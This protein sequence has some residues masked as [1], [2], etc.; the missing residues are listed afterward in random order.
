MV[1]YIKWIEWVMLCEYAVYGH[2]PNRNIHTVSR[3]ERIATLRFFKNLKRRTK[4][5]KKFREGN[6]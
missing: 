2:L 3:R 4:T 6:F 5:I 1:S